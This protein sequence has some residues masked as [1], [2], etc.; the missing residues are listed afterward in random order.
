[1]SKRKD[2]SS[3][4]LHI[5]D[6][7]DG[8]RVSRQ[9]IMIE[10]GVSHTTIIGWESKCDLIAEGRL[11]SAI[12]LLN[13][14]N[15]KTEATYAKEL[16]DRLKAAREALKQP[17]PDHER[18]KQ[19][20]WWITAGRAM[21]RLK[22]GRNTL[23]R[24]ESNCVYIKKSLERRGH[25][26]V[27]SGGRRAGTETMYLESE[28]DAIKAALKVKG[29]GFYGEAAKPRLTARAAQKEF[30]LAPA[31]IRRAVEARLLTPETMDRKNTAK[32]TCET[33]DKDELMKYKRQRD[34]LLVH[35]SISGDR[36]QGRRMKHFDG[37]F[38]SGRLSLKTAARRAKITLYTVRQ[39]VARGRVTAILEK[40]PI[41]TGRPERTVELADV[42]RE[43]ERI[44]AKQREPVPSAPWRR[45]SDLL[46]ALHIS[47]L[48]ERICLGRLLT[49]WRG[50]GDIEYRQARGAY[51]YMA[52][53]VRDRLAGLSPSQAWAKLQAVLDEE[54]TVSVPA[55][56]SQISPL[57]IHLTDRQ[58][59]ILETMLDMELI[60]EV[61]KETHRVIVERI[62]PQHDPDNYKHD[63]AVLRSKGLTD[64]IRGPDG[65]VWLTEKGGLQA[66]QN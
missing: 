4:V 34:S 47:H 49:H 22:C 39:W 36:F 64:S 1:V 66:R 44:A 31:T 54:V 24:W 35:R 58:R 3:Y 59:L 41:G 29:N 10:L 57:P 17:R 6:H 46:D 53:A 60:S 7:P 56:P 11:G 48:G 45:S 42:K 43:K 2:P 62:N 52:Q 37:V 5:F 50:S 33:F 19:G 23:Q 32:Q 25:A 40:P 8:P 20:R 21:T 9:Q 51:Y 55:A 26:R 14:V 61:R 38:P 65:G 63:F 27:L 13:P 18:D 15:G 30:G 28:I 16:Y 12:L